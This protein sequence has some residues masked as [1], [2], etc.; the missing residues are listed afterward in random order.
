MQATKKINL[1]RWLGMAV[2]GGAF[3]VT[4]MA[5]VAG[6]TLDRVMKKGELVVAASATWPPHGFINDDNEYDGFDIDVAKEIA[7]RLGVKLKIDSPKFDLVT[8]GHWK[9]RWDL[10]SF[11]ITPTKARAR[12]L[13]FPAVYYYSTYVFVVHEDSK[14]ETRD[15]LKDVVFGVEGGKTADDYL[16]RDLQID[17]A[18]SPS[19]HYL[20][21]EPKTRTY[22]TSMLPF[23]D[24]RLGD[25]KRIGVIVAELQTAENA[26]KSNY[27]VKILEGDVPFQEPIALATDKGDEEFNAKIAELI[28]EMK[29]DG[30]LEELSYKWFDD[31]YIEL[32]VD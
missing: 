21:F 14:A 20:D 15:D 11:S 2:V 31:D 30:T 3:L 22:A 4:S 10:A 28:D 6:A 32:K 25:N 8:G 18:I 17:G 7:K 26:I 16:Q 23:E 12:L 27:P 9:G 1:A 19:Y 29:A 13:D 5:A 24:L